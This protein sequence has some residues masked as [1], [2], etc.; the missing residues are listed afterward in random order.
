MQFELSTDDESEDE[1]TEAVS[2]GS[3]QYEPC[4]HC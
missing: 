1:V 4:N 2:P 3:T